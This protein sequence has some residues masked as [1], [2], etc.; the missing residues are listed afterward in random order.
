MA[1]LCLIYILLHTQFFSAGANTAF[2]TEFVTILG[3]SVRSAEYQL[4]FMPSL[5]L[6]KSI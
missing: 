3:L 5:F 2:Y 4:S 6:L 1:L